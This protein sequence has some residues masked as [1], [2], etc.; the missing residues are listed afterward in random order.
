MNKTKIP[1]SEFGWDLTRG[2]KHNCLDLSGQPYCYTRRYLKDPLNPK[3]FPERL[4]MPSKITKPS[5]VFVAPSGDIMGEWIKFDFIYSMFKT[6]NNCPRHIFQILTKNP[7]RYQ[8]I[9]EPLFTPNIWIGTSV[10][11]MDDIGRIQLLRE[12]N[13]PNVKFIS[14]EPLLEYVTC[15]LRGID[16]IIIGAKTSHNADTAENL[17]LSKEFAKH[18]FRQIPPKVPV[19]IKPN[20]KWE[21]DI[22][23]MPAEFYKWEREY[24]QADEQQNLF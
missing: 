7:V 12:L 20:L 24:R 14:F 9:I 23:K 8:E 3:I 15:D 22:R 4:S 5:M 11:R 19:F 21:Y 10:T 1:Y 18:L 2:C 6:M 16:W 13:I 17:P